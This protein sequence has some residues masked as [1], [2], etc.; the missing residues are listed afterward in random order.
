MKKN[1]IDNNFEN[2]IKMQTEISGYLS[3][4]IKSI[5]KSPDKSFQIFSDE[6][7]KNISVHFYT[8]RK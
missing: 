7:R 3:H 4:S 1:L 5:Q 8:A 2:V 6:Q